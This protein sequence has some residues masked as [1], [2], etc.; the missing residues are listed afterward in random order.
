MNNERQDIA[1]VLC[2]CGKTL[3]SRLDF[4]QLQDQLKQLPEVKAVKL[5]SNL[6]LKNQCE[7]AVE[8]AAKRAQR[9]LIGACDREVF[10]KDLTK[11]IKAQK[12]NDALVSCINIREHCAWVADNPSKAA[13]KALDT[14]AAA[15][16]RLQYA[17]PVKST[18]T[19]VNQDVLVIGGGVAAMQTSLALSQLGHQVTLAN[20]SKNLGG[21]AAQTPQ[22]YGYIASDSDEAASLVQARLDELI[23]KVNNDSQIKVQNTSA[24]KSIEGQ[25]GNFTTTI[26]SNGSE[27]KVLTGAV[28]LALGASENKSDLLQLAQITENTPKRI[29]IVLDILSEQTR[30]VS[31]QA[32]SAAELLAKQYAAEVK[33]YCRNI[34]VAAPGL[35]QLYRRARDAGAVIVKYDSPPKI[36]GQ[37]TKKV[38]SVQEPLIGKEISEEFDLVIMADAQPT[39]NAAELTS[40]LQGLRT[41]PD[42]ALQYDSVWLLPTNTNRDGIFVAGSARGNS[43]FREAQ[44]DGLAA[45]NQIHELLKDKKIEILE[46]A[47]LV[48][49]DKCVLCLTCMRIC[50]H[51]AITIDVENKV[52]SVSSVTCQRCGT[53]AA[54][55]PAE[56]IQLPRYT[57]SQIAAELNLEQTGK[58]SKPKIVVFAC[59]NSAYPAATAAANN[60]SRWK[61]NFQMIRVPCAGKVDSRDVLHALEAG[62]QKVVLLGCHLENCQYLTGAT[63]AQKRIQ[64]LNNDL[65]KAGVDKK[66]VIF[67]QLASVEP[68][69]FLEYINT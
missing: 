53:C 35:E 38:L 43:E 8:S 59:E 41:G 13:D 51:A 66:K 34:R 48:D 5:C 52:A 14:I 39:E 36:I 42:K 60:G 65:E 28:V 49:P 37:G 54:Q 29:A 18:K 16:R 44:N 40:L 17:E 50:P 30:A 12:L 27:Q 69:K 6:C 22:L 45:A 11:A 3:R 63:R 25:C 68:A 23:E 1:V 19:T 26:S 9:L 61:K 4:D 2:D 20:S 33:L 21:L 64:R 47:A 56:A 67:K 46:D 58:K 15:T 24:V 7:K 57:D 10:D 31:A 55:C 32:L 62:A